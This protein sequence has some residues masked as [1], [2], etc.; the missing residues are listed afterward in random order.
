M[1]T[2]T[3]RKKPLSILN[4]WMRAATADEQDLLAERAGT[5]RG[6]M[7]QLANGHR[8]AS[9]SKAHAIANASQEMAKASKGR[10]PVLYVTDLCEACQ[11]C[12]YAAQVLKDKAVRAEFPVVTGE[13][14]E[15]VKA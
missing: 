12:P 13:T 8:R 6:Q 9:P 1:T 14:L 15:P 3:K 5:T 2:M 11:G 10:L 4:L 7:Y